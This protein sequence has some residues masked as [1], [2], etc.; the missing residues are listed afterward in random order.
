VAAHIRG[1]FRSLCRSIESAQ[2]PGLALNEVILVP[3]RRARRGSASQE[4]VFAPL[5]DPD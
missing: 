3:A 2:P 5:E 4:V 1:G